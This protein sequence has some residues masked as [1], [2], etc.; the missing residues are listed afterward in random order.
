MLN[1]YA[2]GTLQYTSMITGSFISH[3]KPQNKFPCLHL[4]AKKICGI[5][6]SRSFSQFIQ[7]SISGSGI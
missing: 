4:I 6:S 7:P 2:V 3:N 1:S 5:K